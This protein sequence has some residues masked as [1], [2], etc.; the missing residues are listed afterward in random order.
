MMTKPV[1]TSIPQADGS[2]RYVII[3]PVVRNDGNQSSYA[4]GIFKIY[5]DTFGDDITI[6]SN[7]GQ[8]GKPEDRLPDRYNP[9]YLGKFVFK[10]VDSMH[11]EGNVLSPT[12]QVHLAVFIGSYEECNAEHSTSII[13]DLL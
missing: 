3:E 11:F 2:D 5:R 6:I 10:D 1:Q 9:D 7:S 12:E 13:V 8:Y 4:T